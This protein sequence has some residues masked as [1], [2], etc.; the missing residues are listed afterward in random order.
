MGS[1]FGTVSPR[2][3]SFHFQTFASAAS[4]FSDFT[5]HLTRRCAAM[6]KA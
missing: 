6:E 3:S 2:Y 1:E 5:F 4:R